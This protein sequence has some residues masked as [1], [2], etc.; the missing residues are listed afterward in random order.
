MRAV[1]EEDVQIGGQAVVEGVMM[2]SAEMIAIAVRKP[3]GDIIVKKEPYI[4]LSKRIKLF[5]LPI[6]RGAVILIESVVVGIKALIHS[7]NVAAGEESTK[8]SNFGLGLMVSVAFGLGLLL[9]FYLPLV[10]TDRCGIK[11]GVLFNLMDSGI[12]LV[13]FLLY[14]SLLSRWK[15]I[16]RIFQYHGAEHKCISALESKG[17]LTVENAR[18]FSTL[19]PRCGTSFLLI[20]I[21]VSL[22]AFTLLGRPESIGERGLRLLI[23]PLIAGISYELVKLSGRRHYGKIAKIL[24]APGLWLQKITTQEPDDAQLEVALVALKSVLG[25]KVETRSD[26]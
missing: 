11:T 21:V 8:F 15:E 12:R 22:V 19:H 7:G 10:L 26:R 23:I 4:S 25:E 2:R 14:L 20:V 5:G 3:D 6:L 13:I 9:F 1:S 18:K 16:R 17:D 24:I